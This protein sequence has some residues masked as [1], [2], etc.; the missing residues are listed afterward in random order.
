MSIFSFMC[1]KDVCLPFP[2][3]TFSY[4]FSQLMYFKCSLFQFSSHE[5]SYPHF[6]HE[7][8]W[9]L[10]KMISSSIMHFQVWWSNASCLPIR[11]WINKSI[12]YPNL[13]DSLGS[14]WCKI[15]GMRNGCK[16]IKYF[17]PF[18]CIT[19]WLSYIETIKLETCAILY[20]CTYIFKAIT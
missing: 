7:K 14:H 8:P 4:I 19:L 20:I 12:K 6:K 2:F 11:E 16:W 1:T 10:K 9:W 17:A 18:L 5:K 3:T 15:N 13:T